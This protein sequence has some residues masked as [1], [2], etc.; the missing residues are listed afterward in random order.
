MLCDFNEE[1]MATY[2]IYMC[3]TYT[4]QP[5]NSCWH[6]LVVVAHRASEDNSP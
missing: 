5:E 3:S 4:K 1:I 6:L 2:R